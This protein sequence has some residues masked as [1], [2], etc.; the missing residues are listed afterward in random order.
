M[1][2]IIFVLFGEVIKFLLNKKSSLSVSLFSLVSLVS[3]QGF[4]HG[5]NRT[6][7]PE[8]LDNVV[9]LWQTIGWHLAAILMT[10][11]LVYFVHGYFLSEW[12]RENYWILGIVIFL[13]S[14]GAVVLYPLVLLNF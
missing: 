8:S 5:V 6:L 12:R 9:V 11:L 13:V 3:G 4:R 7:S 1:Y 2:G 10:P 14:L